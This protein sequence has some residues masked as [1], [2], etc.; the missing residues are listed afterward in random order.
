MNAL[1]GLLDKPKDNGAS[2]GLAA[3]MGSVGASDT[4]SDAP[5]IARGQLIDLKRKLSGAINS[6]TGIVRSHY[7]NLQALIDTAFDVR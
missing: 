5:A 6:S 2:G 7:Q 1:I 4:P 3:L